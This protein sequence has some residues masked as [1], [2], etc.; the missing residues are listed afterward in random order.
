M[1]G[2]RKQEV[3]MP[4]ST[5]DDPIILARVF[6]PH[7]V[8]PC[9]LDDNIYDGTLSAE[10]NVVLGYRLYAYQSNRPVI[11]YFHGNGEIAPDYDWIAPYFHRLAGVSLLVFDYRGYGW[12][13]GQP[14]FS[15]L[16]S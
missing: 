13:T 6:H 16:L 11:V 9:V 7:A 15:T 4:F 14:S 12:S 5:L 1:N 3:T 2:S 8:F 10:D